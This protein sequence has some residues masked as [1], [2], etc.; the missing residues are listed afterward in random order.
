MIREPWNEDEAK[1]QRTEARLLERLKRMAVRHY[2]I[3][4]TANHHRQTVMGRSELV[5]A[6]RT[7]GE[8]SERLKAHRR[9]NERLNK[10]C[11]PVHGIPLEET[12]REERGVVGTCSRKDCSMGS[13]YSH[14]MWSG[15]G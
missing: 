2:K 12:H 11:C 1:L 3:I 13:S 4:A 10:G 8:A 15:F 7:Y 9:G 6:A 14:E 5:H